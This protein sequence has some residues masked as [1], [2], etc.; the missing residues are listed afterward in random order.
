[1]SPL[2][3]APRCRRYLAVRG[4]MLGARRE[5]GSEVGGGICAVDTVA[6]FAGRYHVWSWSANRARPSWPVAALTVR[7]VAERGVPET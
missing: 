5:T 2:I 3:G 1:M 7:R 4:Q 6:E